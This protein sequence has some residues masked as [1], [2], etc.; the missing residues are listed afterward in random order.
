MSVVKRFHYLQHELHADAVLNQ[1]HNQVCLALEHFVV[2][3]GQRVGVFDGEMQVWSRA[4]TN[5]CILYFPFSPHSEIGGAI[6]SC[7][8]KMYH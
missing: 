3:P 7:S 6:D 1:P 8:M 2:L 4:A 5:I